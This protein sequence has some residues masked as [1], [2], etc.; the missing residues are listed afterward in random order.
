VTNPDLLHFQIT[1]KEVCSLSK[2]EFLARAPPFMGDILWAHLEIL[3][4]DSENDRANIE[5]VPS[6]FSDTTFAAAVAAAAVDSSFGSN[7]QRTYTN[8]DA[9]SHPTTTSC[10]TSSASSAPRYTTVQ[11]PPL[12][13]GGQVQQQQQQV[14]TSSY[15][16]YNSTSGSTVDG[17]EYSYQATNMGN[18]VKYPQQQQQQQQMSRVPVYPPPPPHP[19]HQSAY[20]DQFSDWNV[21]QSPLGVP[22]SQQQQQQGGHDSWHQPSSDFHSSL[23]TS[24]SLGMHHHPAFLQVNSG[25]T[26]IN[27]FAS[28]KSNMDV[29]IEG[30]AYSTIVSLLSRQPV[31][32][33]HLSWAIPTP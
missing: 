24:S 32:P 19:T 15:A 9:S 28:L 3:Q 23:V 17:S 16:D 27:N 22:S 21:Y 30:H 29:N 5:N 10:P 33:A 12:Q 13:R 2:D 25:F 7:Q 1:G 14:I 18:E 20:Q 4:K 26:N 6:N 8:L 31:I 11:P